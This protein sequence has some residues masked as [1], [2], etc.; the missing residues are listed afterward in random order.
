VSAH[1]KVRGLEKKPVKDIARELV[2]Q[3]LQGTDYE[4]VDVQFKSERG[5]WMLTV[6]VDKPGGITL[7]DCE[8]V[9]QMIDPILDSREELAG[10]HDYLVVSSPGL[11]RPIKTD[12]DF[13]RNIGKLLDVKLHTPL[14][15]K[16]EFT[17]TLKAF[18]EGNAYFE[19]A[20]AGAQLEVKRESIA[21]AVQ[22]IEF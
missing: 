11:D 4:L 8:L 15:G 19:V 20:G 9:N 16:R 1:I 21:K 7:A 14:N 12:G 18:D 2:E 6:F 17:G 10:R 22:H 3:G 13:R 5:K